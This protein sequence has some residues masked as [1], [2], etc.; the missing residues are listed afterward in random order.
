MATH[1]ARGALS[2]APDI[3]TTGFDLSERPST[4]RPRQFVNAL[5]WRIAHAVLVNSIR[6]VLEQA[7]AYADRAA[8]EER[9]SALRHA[10]ASTERRR[11]VGSANSSLRR[12]VLRCTE[13]AACRRAA[14]SVMFWRQAS[15]AG[16]LL[17]WRSGTETKSTVADN[18]WPSRAVNVCI[19]GTM[20]QLSATLIR[21]R[22]SLEERG[23][24]SSCWYGVCQRRNKSD[25]LSALK[26]GL[27]NS[28]RN[29]H[30]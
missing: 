27:N 14:A 25:P 8:N 2:S 4:R 24:R 20:R 6:R 28:S 22:F 9:A 18:N 10:I 16:W 3:G 15:T 29:L 30:V 13:N 1:S 5:A 23:T 7:R 11:W 19:V 17:S 21:P 12:A 26:E